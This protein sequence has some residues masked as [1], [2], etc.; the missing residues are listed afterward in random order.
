VTGFC[1]LKVGV[2]SGM[3]LDDSLYLEVV[4]GV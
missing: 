3:G 1:L 2:N 4:W